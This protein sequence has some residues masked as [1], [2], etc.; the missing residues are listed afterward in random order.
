MRKLEPRILWAEDSIG[1]ILLI[2]EAFK[3]AGLKPY[4]IVVNDGVE[5]T[6]FL[7]HKGT[8]VHSRH[9]DLIILDLNMPKKGGREV[10]AEIKTDA[11]LSCIPIIILTSSAQDQDIFKG[12]D[13]KLC[14]Y[15]VKPSG[16]QA[17]VEMAKQ[18]H[19][20]WETFNSPQQQ[21]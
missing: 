3:Q 4:L 2:K 9:P 7:F 14:L 17:L 20:F 5:A 13:P 12:F 16:F 21:S 18:I 15:V 11:E 8:F 1:D 10:I 19:S 6:D